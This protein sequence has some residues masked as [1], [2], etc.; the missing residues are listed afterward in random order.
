MIQPHPGK[1]Y[2]V[3]SL[4]EKNEDVIFH[5][6]DVT[7]EQSILTL[8]EHI[9]KNHGHIDILVN[10]AFM[11]VEE[12]F[13]VPGS[14]LSLDAVRQTM[15]VNFYGPMRVTQALI[16]LIKKAKGG[17]IINISARNSFPRFAFSG[18]LAYKASKAC[19]NILTVDLAKELEN[20]DIA[21]NAVHPG[22]VDTDAGRYVGKGKRPTLT[23]EEGAQSTIWLALESP[24]EVT[25]KFIIDKKIV[26]W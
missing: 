20:D 11:L 3:N 4:L 13:K 2:T 15:E 25:G 24:K 8:T 22:W 7:N 23:I 12:D 26:D 10:N 1:K 19:L 16:P 6:L 18:W 21:V 5:Q 14:Q 17:R 9:E